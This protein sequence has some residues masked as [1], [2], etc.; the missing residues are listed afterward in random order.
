ML[1]TPVS[2]RPATI[3]LRDPMR[4]ASRPIGPF[5]S[6]RL[7]EYADTANPDWVYVSAKASRMSGRSGFRRL[8]LVWCAKCA[9]VIVPSIKRPRRLRSESSSDT[10]TGGASRIAASARAGSVTAL[11]AVSGDGAGS[12]RDEEPAPLVLA[13]GGPRPG[14]GQLHRP[15]VFADEGLEP[16][17]Q[18]AAFEL[19]ERRGG[20]APLQ[21]RPRPTLRP[22]PRPPR[23]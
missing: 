10:R 7:S 2:R 11:C 5:E 17:G 20:P 14:V 15:P 13:P 19:R 23:P 18:H 22:P 16:V 6:P 12:L 1:T 21:P 3:T 8:L 4:S 9:A